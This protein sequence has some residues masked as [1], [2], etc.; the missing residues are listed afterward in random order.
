MFP[1]MKMQEEKM[2]LSE[3]AWEKARRA[4]FFDVIATHGEASA[5]RAGEAAAEPPQTS[6]D[7][8][9]AT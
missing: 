5:Q 8:H 7:R 1:E 9:G 3:P 2:S 6:A 4:G